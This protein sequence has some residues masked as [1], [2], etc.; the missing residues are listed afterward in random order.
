MQARAAS[1]YVWISANNSC[2]R[3]SCWGSFV[4]RPD[5]LIV[6]KAPRHS[7]KVLLN[8]I[9]TGKT[10]YDASVQ[11]RDRAI[12]GVFHS[13]RLVRDERSRNRTAL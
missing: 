12:G 9:D 6:D 8:D 5:G 3:A 7:P 11:W 10:F 4:V 13:G 2:R 1:S